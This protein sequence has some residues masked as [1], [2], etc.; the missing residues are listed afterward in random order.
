MVWSW[1]WF[2][3]H[4]CGPIGPHSDA[5]HV[6][7]E[8]PSNQIKSLLSPIRWAPSFVDLC[9]LCSSSSL[10]VDLVL[11]CILV[12]PSTTLAVVCAGG[13]FALR[14]QASKVVFLSVCCPWFVVQIWLLTFTFVLLSFQDMSSMLLCHLWWAA[15]SLFVNVTVN[16]RTSALYRRVDKIIASYN[17]VFSFRL[18]LFLQIFFILP[19]NDAAFPIRTS[20]YSC[21][22]QMEISKIGKASDQLQPLPRSGTK[23]WRTVVH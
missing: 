18:I 6:S 3:S 17:L 16:G 21:R 12:P 13:P 23:I 11:S 9:W 20:F 14:V 1:L 19:N 10:L 22:S 5:I 2:I 8:L 4:P 15:S 7:K